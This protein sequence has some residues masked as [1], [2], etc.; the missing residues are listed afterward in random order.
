MDRSINADIAAAG[1]TTPQ[2]R[3]HDLHQARTVSRHLHV[4]QT[5]AR[6]AQAR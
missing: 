1:L 6:F 4:F 3:G 2:R 5:T